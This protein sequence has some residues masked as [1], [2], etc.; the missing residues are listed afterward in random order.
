MVSNSASHINGQLMPGVPLTTN[1]KITSQE[2]SAFLARRRCLRALRA[3]AIFMALVTPYAYCNMVLT[4]RM[5]QTAQN[6]LA[7]GIFWYQWWLF[8]RNAG[9]FIRNVRYAPFLASLPLLLNLAYILFYPPGLPWVYN[10][11][12]YFRQFYDDRMEVV[13]MIETGTLPCPPGGR[14]TIALP[15]S[16][17]HTALY[18]KTVE[19]SND[20]GYRIQFYFDKEFYTL[21]WFEYSRQ[22]RDAVPSPNNPRLDILRL[23]PLWAMLSYG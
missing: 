11:E 13:R 8:F 12:Y 15:P 4:C 1:A 18:G 10:Y 14:N 16:L 9:S 7:S 23:A 5:P 21:H 3:M 6:A 2:H 17:N 20:D 22:Y 19:C